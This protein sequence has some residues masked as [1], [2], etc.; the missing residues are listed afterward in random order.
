MRYPVALVPD[1]N[2]TVLVDFP[3]FPEAHT[4]GD[5]NEEALSRAVDALA[6]VIDAYIKDKRDLPAPSTGDVYVDVPALMAAKIELYNAMR[7]QH[8]GKAQLGKRL[9]WHLPQVDRLLD[10]H[11]GS[12]LDQLETA[13]AALGKR[14]VV[15]VA[16]IFGEEPPVVTLQGRDV[17]LRTSP[18][19]LRTH[20]AGPVIARSGT[21]HTSHAVAGSLSTRGARKASARK[22]PK[23][24]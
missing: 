14:L 8:V 19:V 13:F 9:N 21:F 2:G 23:K 10:V 17:R 7:E 22:S 16:D 15:S 4:F 24:R 1:D 12:R 5:D 11:H 6:T 3:D 20:A 18:R